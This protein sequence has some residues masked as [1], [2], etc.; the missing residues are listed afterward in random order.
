M[1]ELE[2]NLPLAPAPAWERLTVD[3]H[4]HKWWGGNV[5]LEPFKKGRFTET[6]TD[7]M[8]QT[9]V[10]VGIIT[11]FDVPARQPLVHQLVDNKEDVPNA[12]ALNSSM[13]NI[14]RLVGPALSGIVL[15]SFGAG[16]CFLINALSFR[17]KI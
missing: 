4:I 14:A 11:A 16:I 15:Q 10:T 5:T 3:A 17:L 7:A 12:V 6:G 8:G 2:F 9:R 1:I 13:V